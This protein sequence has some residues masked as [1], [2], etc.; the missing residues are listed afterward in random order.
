LTAVIVLLLAGF[1]WTVLRNVRTNRILE[2]NAKEKAQLEEEF[3]RDLSEA[4]GQKN[5][6]ESKMA[7]LDKDLQ[8]KEQELEKLRR[9]EAAA[10]HSNAIATFILAA[11]LVRGSDEPEKVVIPANSRTVRLQLNLEKEESY[12]SYVTEIRTARGN[13]VS[14]KDGLV[15]R[16]SKYGQTVALL[17]PRQ[18]VSTGEYEIALKG[19]RRGGTMEVIGYY[20]FIALSR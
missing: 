15:A 6:L 14:S 2:Q 10:E 11:G 19:V 4:E 16:R 13:L 18:I 1:S 8:A 20:Y 17:L 9:A 7:S 3:R 5:D 12:S